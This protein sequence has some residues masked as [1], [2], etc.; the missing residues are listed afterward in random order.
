MSDVPGATVPLGIL[1]L[2]PVSTGSDAA[3]AVR[4]S[5]RLAQ[6]AEVL[7][8]RRYWFAEH[9]LNRG[10]AGTTPAVLVA[11]AAAAT[12]RI[13]VGSGGVQ[14]GHRTPLT[15]VEEFGLL[16]A[17]HPGR[18]DL[19]IGRSG[20]RGFFRDRA[21]RA[22]RAPGLAG[23]SGA[24]R[25]REARYTDTGVLV[26]VAPSL[27]HLAAAPRIVLTAELLQQPQAQ[28]VPYGQFVEEVAGLVA[29]TYRSSEGL[30]PHP[31]PGAGADVEVWVLGSSAGESAE[32]AG[33]LGLRFST[34]Y[35][36]SP[37]TALDAVDAYRR[38]FVP[39]EQL[40]RPY[41]SVSADVVVA[42]DDDEARRLALGYG[43][44][45]RSIRR[46]E[47][48]IEFPSPGEAARHHWSEEDRRLVKDRVDT[49][50]VGSPST[51]ADGLRRL[52][53]ACGADEVLVTT[54]THD[55]ADRERSY[56]LLAREWAGQHERPGT[57]IGSSVRG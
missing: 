37:A 10:V 9:H 3:Q 29:G 39:S 17:A 30:D 44:W 8:Y 6:A 4:N 22:G 21:E 15:V 23:V 36:I 19:G 41:V 5:I 46:G 50:L 38:A 52:Q 42:P 11:L 48:A 34:A 12:A 27:R 43:L 25:P 13:R 57:T 51:V 28:G 54:V 24:E 33:R 56:E 47:G 35:H 1:D 20:G 45:V 26:P 31:V 53:Q 14:S 2:V 18:I 16:D 32:V 7:G 49:Q 55:H 40:E